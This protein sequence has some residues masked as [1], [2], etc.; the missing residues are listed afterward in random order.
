MRFALAILTALL[1]CALASPAGAATGPSLPWRSIGP[2]VSGGRVAAVA[3]TDR[4]PALYYAGAAGG[5][6]WKTTDAGQTWKPVFDATGMPS[7]GAIAIDPND[8]S[9]VWVGTGEGNPR[10]DVSEGN[11]V[12]KTSDGG[13]TW[14]HVLSLANALITAIVVDPKDTKHVLVGVFGDPFADGTDRGVYRTL[15][16]GAT[17]SKVLFAGLSSGISD[18]AMDPHDPALL[19]AGVWEY[20]RTPWSVQSGGDADGL[21][22]SADGGATW[23]KLE[24]H[25]LPDGLQGRIAVA[26]A[27]SNP[28]RVYAIVQSARGLLWR[29]DDGGTNWKMVSADTAIDER[30]FYFSHIFV[31]P[32][33]AD[34]IFSVSVHLVVSEDGGSKFSASGQGLHGDHHAMWIAAGGKRIIEGNDGGVGFSFDGGRSWKRDANIPISQLYHVGYSRENPYRVCAALQ[35][36]GI[37]CAPANP[38]DPRGVSAS[39]WIFANGGDGTWAEFDPRDPAIVWTA[40]AGGNNGGD[41]YIADFARGQTRPIA[42]YERDQNAVDPAKLE[43]RFN[44]E[45]PIAFDPFDARVAYAGGERL[46]VTRNRGVTWTTAGPDLTRNAKEHQVITG[47]ITLDGTGAETSDT[48]LFIAPSQVAQGEIWAGTDDGLVQLTRDGGRTWKNVTP[49]GIAPWGR[50]ASISLSRAN[51]G[52]ALAA[53]DRHML[54]D[55]KPYLFLTRDFGAHWQSVAGGLPGDDQSVRSALL[56]PRDERVFFAGME[57]SLWMS[58]DAGGH[59]EQVGGLPPASIR[60]IRLQ[61]DSGDIVLATHGR[62]TYV[63]DDATPLERFDRARTAGVD[64][65]DVRPATRWE[66]QSYYRT[67]TDGAGPPYGAIV[68]YYLTSAAREPPTAEILDARGDVVRRYDARTEEGKRVSDLP[69]DAGL[70]R[71][72]WDL[73]TDPATPW[74]AAPDWNQGSDGVAVVPGRYRVRLHLD[75]RTFERSITVLADPRAQYARADYETAYE[76]QKLM[77]D[78]LSRVDAALNILSNAKK[79]ALAPSLAE[80]VNGMIASLTSNPANDQDDDFLTDVLRERLQAM[81]GV[82]QSS[83]APPTASQLREA[84]ALHE[85][86][87][88]RMNA[89]AVL[90]PRLPALPATP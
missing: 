59:W 15:D 48:L 14:T 78:D 26:F 11:G 16:G 42:P 77:L 10:N 29:S 68:S 47:G 83:F 38:L 18:L 85:L 82:L 43:H 62:G 76:L 87:V 64:V 51:A 72:A 34:R 45:T 73:A 24:G 89:F 44:W 53:Y 88:E 46:F 54:G 20:R 69:N 81:L 57:R 17:W 12:Y 79:A 36:N 3:G 74:R 90:Q 28:Q 40:V 80:S 21:Y 33:N 50:F 32:E 9:T 65:F 70:N 6:V 25:G 71:F 13:K 30:P 5:G 61:P 56:D 27:P 7:I 37:F 4:D 31:D 60:D 41:L 66:L 84:A 75:G 35:D 55:R 63:F 39:Q 19:F 52:T 58:W 49:A 22:R 1:A 23:T 67:A 86:T 2:A 8:T